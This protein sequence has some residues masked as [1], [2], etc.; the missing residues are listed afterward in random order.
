VYGILLDSYEEHSQG[1]FAARFSSNISVI[2]SVKAA[3]RRQDI[4]VYRYSHTITLVLH[5][6]TSVLHIVELVL[7]TVTVVHHI[8]T[9]VR[10]IVTLALQFVT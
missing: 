7:H 2:R 1:S 8:V 6:C 4:W 5:I 10:H 3:T 9:S